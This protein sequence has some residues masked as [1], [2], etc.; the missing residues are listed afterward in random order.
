[1][2]SSRWPPEMAPMSKSFTSG[3]GGIAAAGRTMNVPAVASAASMRPKDR[4]CIDGSFVGL[5]SPLG[6][7]ATGRA[8]DQ[9]SCNHP[10]AEALSA[11][12]PRSVC[13]TEPDPVVGGRVGQRRRR[14]ADPQLRVEKPHAVGLP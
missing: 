13:V 9:M 1:M 2:L 14:G 5:L 3:V 10:L 4:K 7:A 6:S 8:L 12:V 11:E